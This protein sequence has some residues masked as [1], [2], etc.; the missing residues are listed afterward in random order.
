[1]TPDE[2][3]AII[4]HRCPELT[5]DDLA[6]LA[7]PDA[8][9]LPVEVADLILDAVEALAAKVEMLVARLPAERNR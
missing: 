1:M 2:V 8:D 5:D 9:A 4:H 3:R 6:A 7:G